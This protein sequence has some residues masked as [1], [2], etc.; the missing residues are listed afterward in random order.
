MSQNIA[1]RAED[2]DAAWFQAE[3]AAR[4]HASFMPRLAE[5]LQ[6][7]ARDRVLALNAGS[8]S[9]ALLL[10]P[11]VGEILAVD[12]RS[13]LLA[14]GARRAARA[15]IRNVVFMEGGPSELTRL[16]LY[17]TFKAA[18]VD[19]ASS[20]LALPDELFAGLD[21]VIDQSDG[22]L[23]F[24]S[25]ELGTPI[26]GSN[27]PLYGWRKRLAQL[28]DQFAPGL[29][30]EAGRARRSTAELLAHSA[31]TRVER[32]RSEYEI[33]EQPCL[34]AAI[35]LFY[36]HASVLERLGHRRVVFER[37]AKDEFGWVDRLPPVSVKRTDVAVLAR[38]PAS[39]A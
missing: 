11:N 1:R 12:S 5:R 26:G 38:R 31:F 3:Y 10:A 9:T 24:V 18:I 21:P 23:A 32:L 6:L 4:P 2:D 39:V 8:G 33:V 29:L 27:E 7:A 37:V 20:W 15:G 13:D 30:V 14:E 28:L 35:G 19:A 16:A 34:D 25:A 36:S 22:A 17:G